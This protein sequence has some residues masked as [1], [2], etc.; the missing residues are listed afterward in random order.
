MAPQ[1]AEDTFMDNTETNLRKFY[2]TLDNWEL[3]ALDRH[4]WNEVTHEGAVAY[5][6]QSD[7]SKKKDS[8]KLQPHHTLSHSPFHNAP[9]YVNPEYASAVISGPTSSPSE[10]SHTCFRV[11]AD[12]F[13]S[14]LL[15]HTSV[16][17]KSDVK[18]RRL[19][20]KVR[21]GR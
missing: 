18:T 13:I 5:E 10:D 3:I 14:F 1:W 2:V 11:T 12:D 6:S 17:Q 4:L 16:A 15:C 21:C 19:P 7:N 20:L 9:K 8:Q